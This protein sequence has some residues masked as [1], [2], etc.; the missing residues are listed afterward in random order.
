[1]RLL[2]AAVVVA[3]VAPGG[4]KAEQ[5]TANA[6]ASWQRFMNL[7]LD[8]LPR[9]F[10]GNE[11]CAPATAEERRNPPLSQAQAKLIVS[12]AAN[13]SMAEHC[14]LDWQ[15]RN[16]LPL[17]QLHRQ[18]FKMS[19]RQ[20][21]LVGLLHGITMGVVGG[22]VKGKPCAPETKAAVEGKLLV[23]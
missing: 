21:A 5:S 14:G 12:A 4:A 20:M 6:D 22:T 13:S 2:V 15:R 17:M 8:N 9:A 23:K 1:M 7:A 19:E 10:C 18:R 16:F 11:K 3:I